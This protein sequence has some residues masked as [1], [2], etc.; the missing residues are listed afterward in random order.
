MYGIIPSMISQRAMTYC[1]HLSLQLKT[2]I[3]LYSYHPYPCPICKFFYTVGCPAGLC[4]IFSILLF[5]CGA[6]G[7]Q[8]GKSYTMCLCHWFIL[9]TPW[10]IFC[11]LLYSFPS[12]CSSLAFNWGGITIISD[13]FK[14]IGTVY[15]H[16]H[17][18][19]LHLIFICREFHPSFL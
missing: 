3:L 8:S 6:S 14:F 12:F 5:P 18:T 4:C 15:M 11:F 10:C 19:V 16:T 9:V 1:S 2:S 7:I 13:N 17:I